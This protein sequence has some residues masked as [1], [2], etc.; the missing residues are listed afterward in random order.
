MKYLTIIIT[1][2]LIPFLT[3][4]HAEENDRDGYDENTEITVSGTVLETFRDMPCGGMRG[5]R[6][7]P[8]IVKLRTKTRV[9]LVITAPFWYL[10]QQ[11]IDFPAATPLEVSGSKFAG[12]DG[13]L[14]L[15][16]RSVRFAESGRTLPLRDDAYIPL[17]RG[18]RMHRMGMFRSL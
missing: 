5:C 14:Y 17:W 3:S 16:A 1:L 12:T 8:V 9:Y 13:N 10:K 6:G 15:I 4:A 2:C 11:N 18:T 7:G